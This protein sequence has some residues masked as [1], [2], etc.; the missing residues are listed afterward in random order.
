MR[1][2]AIVSLSLLGACQAPPP[3]TLDAVLYRKEQLVSAPWTV[4]GRS[5]DLEV[6]Q[7][8]LVA[9]DPASALAVAAFSIVHHLDI[10]NFYSRPP[11]F[12][13]CVAVDDSERPW[14]ERE[15]VVVDW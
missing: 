8:G 3:L 1:L 2:F 7:A 10:V 4:D 14:Q 15:L 13:D 6:R 5:V 12:E 9:R 11:G